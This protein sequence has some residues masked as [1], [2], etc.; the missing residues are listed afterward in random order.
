MYYLNDG[1]G[2]RLRCRPD[3]GKTWMYRYR[4]NG[5]EK[6]VGIGSYPKFTLKIARTVAAEYRALI[7][8]GKNPSIVPRQHHVDQIG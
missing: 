7:L 5:V 1:G 3:G 6:S 8:E 4:F 2:L